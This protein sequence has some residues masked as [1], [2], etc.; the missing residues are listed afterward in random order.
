MIF[1]STQTP[2][3]CLKSIL[4]ILMYTLP[5]LHPHTH[6]HTHT[7]PHTHT[8]THTH[9]HSYSSLAHTYTAQGIL[10][11]QI[12]SYVIATT[13][14]REYINITLPS[15]GYVNIMMYTDAYQFQHL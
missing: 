7:H 13:K 12:L 2:P 10:A 11:K 14:C 5:T 3:P 4:A 1:I 15:P 6:T 9:T 8:H